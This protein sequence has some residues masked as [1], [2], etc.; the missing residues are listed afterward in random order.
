M[1][2]MSRAGHACNNLLLCFSEHADFGRVSILHVRPR[3]ERTPAGIGRSLVP[4]LVGLGAAL[5][6]A[7]PARASPVLQRFPG[8]VWN[9]GTILPLFRLFYLL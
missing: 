7:R 9:A 6:T 3:S 4:A 2:T 1:Q 8:I 5:R